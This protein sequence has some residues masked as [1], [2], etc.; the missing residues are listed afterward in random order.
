M[1]LFE[2]LTFAVAVVSLL[3]GA[4]Y[5]LLQLYFSKAKETEDLKTANV[6]EALAMIGNSISTLTLRVKDIEKDVTS[7]ISSFKDQIHGLELRLTEH[8][9]EL[10]ASRDSMGAIQKSFLEALKTMN[11]YQAV[12]I[13]EDAY[14]VTAKKKEKP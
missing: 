11:K 4:G 3:T 7:M 6:K 9:T 14:R 2:W 12:P 5:F 8:A 1:T 13:G 10:R